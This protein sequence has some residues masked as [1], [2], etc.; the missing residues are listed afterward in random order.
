MSVIFQSTLRR[1]TLGL[2]IGFGVGL[3][4]GVVGFGEPWQEAAVPA[5]GNGIG[6]AVVFYFFLRDVTDTEQSGT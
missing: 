2:L 5:V 6:L 4:T 1:A 3:L